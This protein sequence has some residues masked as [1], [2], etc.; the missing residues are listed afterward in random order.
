MLRGQL[1]QFLHCLEA[2]AVKSLLQGLQNGHEL[3]QIVLL[4]ESQ[5]VLRVGFLLR[6]LPNL[7][8]CVVFVR[9]LVVVDLTQVFADLT[10]KCGLREVR[11]VLLV[12]RSCVQI[13]VNWIRAEIRT[14]NWGLAFWCLRVNELLV[15][16]LQVRS[17]RRSWETLLTQF[18]SI[19]KPLLRVTCLLKHVLLRIHQISGSSGLRVVELLVQERHR[20]VMRDSTF[21]KLRRPVIHLLNFLPGVAT[22]ARIVMIFV[23]LL[24]VLLLLVHL[25]HG[26]VLRLGLFLLLTHVVR[27]VGR[28]LRQALRHDISFD[29]VR[30]VLIW[31]F[32]A[33]HWLI[34]FLERIVLHV[35]VRPKLRIG[36]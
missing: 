19:H 28:K 13:A 8:Y 33:I 6:E 18:W 15:A 30:W 3:S 32:V 17:R 20:V 34:V 27:G 26:C 4:E 7:L 2:G 24:G 9:V 10:I 31:H 23:V 1:S 29:F 35:S 16:S 14:P 21:V 5:N 22:V 36:R 25:H 11:L 12:R